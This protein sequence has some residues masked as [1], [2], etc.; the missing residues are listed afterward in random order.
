M[1]SLLTNP[2]SVP[3][4]VTAD[5]QPLLAR[6]SAGNFGLN[7]ITLTNWDTSTT[8][9]QVAAGSKIDIMG[10]IASFPADE[11]I[12]G[13]PADGTV[14]LEFV[15][16][17]TAVTA[18]W[19]NTAPT[20]DAGKG[21]WAAGGNVYSGHNCVKSG[22]SYTVKNLIGHNQ[23]GKETRLEPTQL[24][25]NKI[26]IT[27]PSLWTGTYGT[28]TINSNTSMVI[29]AGGFMIT[30]TDPGNCVL[31]IK[32]AASTWFG[33]GDVGGFVVSDGASYRLRVGAA[34]QIIYYRKIW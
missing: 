22:A 21:Q 3:V 10:S 5:W 8:A 32:N 11:A 33:I 18:Q 6:D 30:P 26:A 24:S 29:P 2:S 23:N 9:P 4:S 12:G 25:V 7:M 19:T 16:N 27:D 17:G 28:W 13:S 1:G 15:V 14:W 34:Q 20:W 31:E